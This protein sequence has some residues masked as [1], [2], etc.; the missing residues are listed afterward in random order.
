MAV[1]S[2]G[3]INFENS[4]KPHSA[5]VHAPLLGGACKNTKMTSIE[6]LYFRPKTWEDQGTIYKI[7]GVLIFKTL[8][9]TLCRQ[10]GANSTRPNPHYLW[11][12][13]VAGI[14]AYEKRTRYSEAIHLVGIIAPIINLV[15]GNN[16]LPVQIIS[17]IVLGLNIHPVLLQR[18]N[19]IRLYRVLKIETTANKWL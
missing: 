2:A 17:W 18:Y 3:C 1:A 8:L 4:I 12:K 11:Q 9:T 19:R 16:A 7:C 15:M 14:R 10:V 6:E 5:C 13:D